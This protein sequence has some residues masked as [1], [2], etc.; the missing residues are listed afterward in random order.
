MTGGNI[1]VAQAY[2]IEVM[3]KEAE[4]NL[5]HFLMAAGVGVYFAAGLSGVLTRHEPRMPFWFAAP[6]PVIDRADDAHHTG[7]VPFAY[8]TRYQPDEQAA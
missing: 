8:T 1:I 6:I 3:A 4:R 5:I 7:R 2:F